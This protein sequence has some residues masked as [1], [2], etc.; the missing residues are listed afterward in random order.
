MKPFKIVLLLLFTMY[1]Q[2]S[3]CSQD[4]TQYYQLIDSAE[5]YIGN[6]D[7]VKGDTYYQKGLNTFRGFPDDYDQAILN[8]YIVYNKLDLDLIKAGFSN[9]LL[10]RDLKYSLD[11]YN[12]PYSKRELKKIY[13]KNK[14]KKKKGSLPVYFAMIRDQRSRSKKNGDIAKAD[15]I[16][17][18]KLKKWM[19]KK[20]HLF[21]RFDTRLSG[22]EMIGVLM[23][24]TGWKNLASVQD[25]LYNLTK[26]GLIHRNVLGQ[27][28]ERSA[29]YG[30]YIFTLDP[31]HHKIA[32][33]EGGQNVMCY[34]LSYSN[35]FQRYGE[36]YDAE[37][38]AFLLPPIHPSFSEEEINKLRNHLFFSD[39]TLLYGNPRYMKVSA[40]EYC[41]FEMK[42]IEK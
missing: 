31:V 5:Y 40:E 3:V 25:T 2:S 37:R 23:I 28:I 38:E 29:L 4:Y 11:M 21:N 24:H 15:A 12:A 19:I 34:G 7:L 13:R 30:G 1:F 18:V 17:A 32:W 6:Q 27:I 10:F 16:T 35:I 33:R 9:G 42:R 39:V 41:E 22:S 36:I 8:N 14:L 26:K 20:P